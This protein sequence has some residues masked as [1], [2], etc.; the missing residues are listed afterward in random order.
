[1]FCKFSMFASSLV[2]ISTLQMMLRELL[3]LK[4]GRCRGECLDMVK[5][6]R[7]II[8]NKSLFEAWEFAST[9]P[10]RPINWHGLSNLWK[11]IMM[12]PVSIVI[13]ERGFSK[14]NLIKSHIRTNLK[15]ETLDA[16]MCISCANLFVSFVIFEKNY[17]IFFGTRPK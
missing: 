7:E 9:T 5:T 2:P 12:I 6:L 3:L 14:Q 1:M 17:Q 10:K 15:L 13:C 8:P 4:S 11:R 16:L